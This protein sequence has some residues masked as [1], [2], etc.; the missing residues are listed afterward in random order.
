MNEIARFNINIPDDDI[1]D[2]KRRLAATRWLSFS[3]VRGGGG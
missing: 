3:T 1:A 2:L